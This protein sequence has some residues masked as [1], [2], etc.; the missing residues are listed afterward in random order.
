MDNIHF[1]LEVKTAWFFLTL[2]SKGEK[3]GLRK[4]KGSDIGL[5][6]GDPFSH[7]KCRGFSTI[8]C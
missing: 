8:L 6:T 1:Y 4:K 5:V 2:N 3:M 7:L